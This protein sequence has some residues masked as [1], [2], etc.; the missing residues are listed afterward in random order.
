VDLALLFVGAAR[1]ALMD[2]A[3]L[4]LTSEQAALAARTLGARRVIPLHFEGWAH[5]SEGRQ[6]LL[7]AFAA[8]GLT[9]RVTLLDLGAKVVA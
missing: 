7:D 5:F 9:E 4:T 2:G 8:A 3:P 1:T 6:S